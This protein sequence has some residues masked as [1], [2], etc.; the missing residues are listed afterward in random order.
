M[1]H[2]HYDIGLV[3]GSV[4]VAI[5]TCYLAV[6]VEQLL[7]WGNRKK[8]EKLILIGCGAL[9]GAA[10]WSMHFVGMLACHLPSTY[11]LDYPLTFVSYVIAFIAST[12]AV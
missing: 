4:A 11:H 5:L 3:L 1:V 2:V 9:L 6:S 10:I 12:F 7:F 8:Y